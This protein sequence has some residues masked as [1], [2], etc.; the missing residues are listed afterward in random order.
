MY[1]RV[2]S[3]EGGDLERLREFTEEQR[4]KGADGLP[5]GVRRVQLLQDGDANRRLFIVYFD[6]REQAEAAE[7]HFDRMGDDIDESVRGKR[8]SVARYEVIFDDTP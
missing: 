7:E 5:D 4:A 6:S 8:T 2:A 3:F 1:A